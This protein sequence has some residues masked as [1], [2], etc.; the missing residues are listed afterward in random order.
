MEQQ[1]IITSKKNSNNISVLV[2]V[3]VGFDH[4]TDSENG[5]AHFLEHMYFKGTEK[6]KTPKELLVYLDSLGVYANAS[7]NNS[8]TCYYLSGLK[9]K[10]IKNFRSCFRYVFKFH[11]SIRRNAKRKRCDIRRNQ[12]AQCYPY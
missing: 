2:G 4:E 8:S 6:Y 11:I 3:S 5:L 1:L 7:T 9:D 10:Y 12:N